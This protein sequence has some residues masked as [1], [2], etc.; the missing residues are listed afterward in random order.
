MAFFSKG[1]GVR[2]LALSI[3]ENEMIIVLLA[4][5]KWHVYLVG[6]PF[7]IRTDHQSFRFLSDR[8]SITPYQQKWVAKMLG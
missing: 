5:K 6:R 7:L 2:H 1:L 4:V 8:H 3:Y